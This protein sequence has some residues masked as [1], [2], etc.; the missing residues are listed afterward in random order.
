MA[1]LMLLGWGAVAML[2]AEQQFAFPNASGGSATAA[3]LGCLSQRWLVSRLLPVV[4]GCRHEWL[5]T[6][7]TVCC[8]K[9]LDTSQTRRHKR[10]GQWHRVPLN[11]M[12]GA[13][14]SFLAVQ[15]ARKLLAHAGRMLHPKLSWQ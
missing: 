8:H 1:V 4:T 10:S 9:Q 7:V 2:V 6:G 12:A 13:A 14:A 15:T 11:C 5:V 3:R